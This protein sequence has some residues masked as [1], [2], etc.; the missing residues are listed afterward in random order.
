[1]KSREWGED[2]T[3]DT[4]LRVWQW[5]PKMREPSE[6]VLVTVCYRT[7]ARLCVDAWRGKRGKEYR[8]GRMEPHG[9]GDGGVGDYLSNREMG[10]FDGQLY[11]DANDDVL[12]VEVEAMLGQLKPEY[13][14][15][16]RLAR[17]DEYEN[18]DGAAMLGLTVPAY[19]ARLRRGLAQLRRLND[20]L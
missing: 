7:M 14:D 19:K 8:M 13:R 15:V 20:G 1:M 9:T 5:L 18:N 12:G 3:Q 16:V 4:Y 6:A 10:V 2:I 17:L 11:A